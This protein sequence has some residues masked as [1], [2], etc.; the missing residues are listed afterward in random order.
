MIF[1][2]QTA[3]HRRFFFSSAQ[4]TQALNLEPKVKGGPQGTIGGRGGVTKDPS[5]DPSARRYRSSKRD[6]RRHRKPRGRR[7]R[8]AAGGEPMP[9][10][11][12][13][14]ENPCREENAGGAPEN[15]EAVPEV[16][17]QTCEPPERRVGEPRGA[18]PK[19][20]EG[21]NRLSKREKADSGHRTQ[22]TQTGSR[23]QEKRRR[24]PVEVPHKMN[25]VSRS[26][27]RVRRQGINQ[28][29]FIETCLPAK[30]C[31]SNLF[32]G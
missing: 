11:G 5:T 2:S 26:Y 6:V 27:S 15:G 7:R 20:G 9:R 19:G 8:H 30:P 24:D 1:P 4:C 17:T 13:N 12:E 10:D 28:R 23:L 21:G 16:V 31:S 25:P 32:A 14:R 3:L 29:R 18:T 22:R